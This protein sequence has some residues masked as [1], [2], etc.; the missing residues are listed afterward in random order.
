MKLD[1]QMFGGRGQ[2]SSI[3]KKNNTLEY[4]TMMKYTNTGRNSDFKDYVQLDNGV[5]IARDKRNTYSVIEKDIFVVDGEKIPT[6]DKYMQTNS[7]MQKDLLKIDKKRFIK[8]SR[9]NK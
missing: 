1:I 4:T 2:N 7:S 6:N 5:I 9:R 8:I 3:A